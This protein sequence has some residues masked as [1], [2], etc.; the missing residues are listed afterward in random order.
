MPVYCGDME[1]PATPTLPAPSSRPAEPTGD[2]TALRV[3][4]MAL[5]NGVLMRSKRYWALARDDGT[6]LDGSVRSLLDRHRVLRLPIVRGAVTFGE[7]LVFAVRLHGRGGARPNGRL[8]VALVLCG[9]AAALLG[10]SVPGLDTGSLAAGVGLELATVLL[11]LL[12]LHW[13][14]G[15]EVWRYH[16]AE[17][18]AVNAY[19]AGAD[20]SDATSVLGFSRIHDRC[21]TNL[22]VIVVALSLVCLPLSAGPLGTTLSP[23]YGLLALALAFELFRLVTR[24][25]HLPACRAVLAGGKALQRCLTTRDPRPEQQRVACLALR[26]VVEL[27]QAAQLQ[28]SLLGRDGG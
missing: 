9:M 25:P 2:A 10:E 4:G 18:K 17:H 19:E 23:L 28:P 21:G 11:G 12:A 7:M 5:G 26:R 13:G 20:L 24:R 15:A 3:G 22:V 27:E 1:S 16:G 14:M 6:V 8:L